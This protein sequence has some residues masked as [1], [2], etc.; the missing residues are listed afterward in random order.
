MSTTV[1][2][3]PE[4]LKPFL[5]SEAM[6]SLVSGPVGCLAGDTLVLTEFGPTPIADID[7]P[8]RVLSWN[9]K[10]CRFQLSL[11]SGSFPKGRDYLFRVVTPQGEFDAAGHH[12]LLC[13]DGKYRRVESLRRGD[14][15]SSYSDTPLQ[16]TEELCRP[17][18]PSDAPR[19]SQTHV[20]YLANYAALA[21]RCGRPFLSE[22]GSG[23][24][25]SPT[26][27]D[28]RICGECFSPVAAARVGGLSGRTHTHT[29][30]GLRGGPPHTPSF[31]RP[32]GSTLE[33]EE[34]RGAGGFFARVGGLARLVQRS[35]WNFGTRLRTGLLD[36]RSRGLVQCVLSLPSPSLCTSN[37]PIISI[38][39]LNVKQAFWD[40]QVM[41]TNNYVTADGAIH[42]NS[43]KTSAALLKIAYHAKQM[44]K[45]QDG[46]R[47]SR[48]VVI[49]NTNQQLSDTTIPSF[50][51]WF[52]DGAAGAYLRTEKK[53]ILRFDD[54]DCEILFRGLDDV[55]DI[56]R[57]LSLEVSFGVMDEYREIHPDIFN[58]LQGRIGRYPSVKDGGCVKD[59]G[60]PNYHIWGA[61]N[62]PDADT[63]WEDYMST[64]PKTAEIF[65]QPS[66]LSQEADWTQYLVAGYY[67]NLAEGKTEDWVSVYIHNQFGR[68]L[69]GMPVFRAFSTELHVA[70]EPLRPSPMFGTLLIG[71]DAG[72]T[73]AATIG[74]VDVSG[75]ILIYDCLISEG[76][77]ALRFIREK[78]KPLLA[79][80]YPGYTTSV[81]A[82]PA[83][84]QRAQSDERTV[85]DMY[86][87]EGF[88]V[89]PAR[90][91]SIAARIGAVD[92]YLTRTIDEHSALL[93]DA[94][95]G[96]HLITAMRG[97][98]RYKV[99]KKG[100]T[101]DSPE[102]SHPHSDVVDSFMYLSLHADN[103]ASMGGN[104]S[105]GAKREIE[106]APHRG[107]T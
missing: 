18:S 52:P 78:L 13:A 25:V 2:T 79:S 61:T 106:A 60:T 102:K 10:T 70:K 45:Q 83:S 105:S 73:P 64:P 19:Y 54:V 100:E 40:M 77:G 99:N 76:M 55:Q 87:A 17:T 81:I 75:R 57:L 39:R 31:A 65:K 66:A 41:D 29:R 103:G 96:K 50:T 27:V 85:A 47:R 15:L 34:G 90:T 4:S 82:D 92:N 49:R 28:A 101:D 36:V 98:Y 53:F 1:Y 72:L 46:I 74:Q 93:I 30:L 11:S 24:D 7:R 68:T 23:Q 16:T 3:P 91:N 33:T 6:V 71:V 89:R 44:R 20:D 69:S 26:Q 9:E 62:A 56:R 43:G 48:A 38:T 5:L 95:G 94:E 59:D 8:M 107:W 58:A 104:R 21:R 37:R 22:E 12:L 14:A 86:K 32:S 80:K 88:S 67:E 51:T 84:W 42:H 63:F 97:K 35:L